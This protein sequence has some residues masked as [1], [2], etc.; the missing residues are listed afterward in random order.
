MKT[1]KDKIKEDIFVETLGSNTMI[2]S[3]DEIVKGS[4]SSNRDKEVDKRD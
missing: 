2:K 4:N 3:V 1:N